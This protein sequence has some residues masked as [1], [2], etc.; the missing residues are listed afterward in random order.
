MEK[1]PSERVS[2]FYYIDTL[3]NIS[4]DFFQIYGA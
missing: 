4:I 1:C 2:K 3:N